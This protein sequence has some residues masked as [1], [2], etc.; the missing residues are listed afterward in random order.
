MSKLLQQADLAPGSDSLRPPQIVQSVILFSA[1]YY[2]GGIVGLQFHF[3]PSGI[4]VIWPSTAILLSALLLTPPRYWWMYLLAVV[5]AHLHL[6]ISF[7]NPNPSVVVALCQVANNV[8]EAVLAALVVRHVIGAPPRFD[9]LHKMAAFILLVGIMTNA[10]AC[11]SAVSLFLLTGWAADFWLAWHQ[12]VLAG[13]FPLIT[14]PPLILLARTGQLVRSQRTPLRSYAELGLLTTGL[15]AVGV[16]VLGWD[17]QGLGNLPGLLLAP[18]PL[19]LW[20]AVRLGTGGLSL[21]LLVVAGIALANGYFGRG[22]FQTQSSAGNVLSLQI[23]L[24]AISIPLMLLA[25]LVEERGRTEQSLRA[26]ERELARVSRQ[27]TVGAMAASIAHEINQPLSA[28]VTNGSIGLRL[29]ANADS[30]L[31]EVREVLKRMIDDGFRASNII[32]SIRAMF[33]KERREKSLVSTRDL[34]SEVLA[35]VRGE[36]ESHRVSLQLELHQELPPVMGDRLQLQQVLL[37]LIMNAVEAMSSVEGRERSLLV[38]SELHGAGDLLITVEDSG[39]GI[40]PNDMN[41]IFDALFTTKSHGM[42][43]GLSICQSII[44]SHGGRLWASARVPHGAVF[45]IQLPSG[46]AVSQ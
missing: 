43:L 23:F 6:V 20:A 16:P 25:A 41:R 8:V 18:L 3:P 9:S 12:R 39:P 4:T 32:S 1:G 17:P 15:L 34:V 27:T 38:K 42:G 2:V 28:L 33:G 30:D 13:T 37:N 19:L 7:Q 46:T 21:S 45:Y 31:D 40:D 22:P 26:T 36:L 5:P 14:I 35:L 10:I 29:L 44:A 24:L 11:A